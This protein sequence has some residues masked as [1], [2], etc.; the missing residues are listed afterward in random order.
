MPLAGEAIG[1]QALDQIRVG[2][3]VLQAIEARRQPRRRIVVPALEEALLDVVDGGTVAAAAERGL[4]V[5][6]VVQ[7][8]QEV[9]GVGRAALGLARPPDSAVSPAARLAPSDWIRSG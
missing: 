5:G 6:I 4:D 3:D 1:P 8:A 2:R 9:E 7:V